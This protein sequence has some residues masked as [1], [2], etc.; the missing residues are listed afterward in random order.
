M[1]PVTRPA[2]LLT[3]L[4][5]TACAKDQIMP[6][7]FTTPVTAIRELCHL[8]PETN[9]KASLAKQ[10]GTATPNM[11]VLDVQPPA[12]LTSLTVGSIGSDRAAL[13]VNLTYQQAHKP[14]VGELETAFGPHRQIPPEDDSFHSTA[15]FNV[16]VRG[17]ECVVFADTDDLYLKIPPTG[18]VM[19]VTVRYDRL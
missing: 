14:T 15:A 11:D 7:D 10:L 9:D 1:N 6:I 17:G 12:G 5:L 8:M 16:P 4:L 19:K 2:C 3:L 13:W 18:T